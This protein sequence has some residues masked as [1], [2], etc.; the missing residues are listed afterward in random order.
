MPA[1]PEGKDKEHLIAAQQLCRFS[2]DPGGPSVTI[3]QGQAE[4]PVAGTGDRSV[5]PAGGE[6][7]RIRMEVDRIHGGFP[8]GFDLIC[9]IGKALGA[10]TRQ[11]LCLHL[12]K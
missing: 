2:V 9:I 1:L 5:D 11:L 12:M 8:Q 3:G 6:G 7:I 10:D 4:Q